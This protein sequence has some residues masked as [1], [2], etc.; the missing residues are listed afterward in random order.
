MGAELFITENTGITELL[1]SHIISKHRQFTRLPSTIHKGL[2]R[3][4]GARDKKQ[5]WRPMFEPEVLRKQMYCIEES[6]CDIIGTFRRPP[7]W[8]GAP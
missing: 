3:L 6:I 1:E 2:T 5:V 7:Q 8:F 4:H